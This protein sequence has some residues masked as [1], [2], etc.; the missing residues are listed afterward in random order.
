MGVWVLVLRLERLMKRAGALPLAARTRM[1]FKRYWMGW[2]DA[3]PPFSGMVAASEL[4][5]W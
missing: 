5:S 4:V 2:P 1:R 3:G